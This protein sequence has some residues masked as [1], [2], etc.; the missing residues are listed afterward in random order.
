MRVPG[1]A[2]HLAAIADALDDEDHVGRRRS[3]NCALQSRNSKHNV[4]TRTLRPRN[5]RDDDVHRRRPGR[6]RSDI[7]V[8]LRLGAVHT[9]LDTARPRRALQLGK[10]KIPPAAHPRSLCS[11]AAIGSAKSGVARRC[12]SSRLGSWS[13]TPSRHW[14]WAQP[15][16][17]REHRLTAQRTRGRQNRPGPTS[18]TC[19]RHNTIF[20]PLTAKFFVTVPRRENSAHGLPKNR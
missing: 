6:R 5:A 11:S 9:K 7:G 13:I 10:A 3:G 19:V 15:R 1:H 12:G 16:D 17:A 4:L 2:R 14:Y 20:L 18:Q 8:R